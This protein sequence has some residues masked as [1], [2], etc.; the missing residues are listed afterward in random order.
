MVL[1]TN[2]CNLW[3][4]YRATNDADLRQQ[5]ILRY[6]PLVRYVV[7]R[8]ALGLRSILDRDDISSYGTMGLIDAIGHFDPGRGFKFET[9]AISRIRG[10]ILD[11]MRRLGP[12]PRGTRRKM[13]KIA[14]AIAALQ[15]QNGRSP[16]EDEVAGYLGIEIAEYGRALVEASF[17]IVPLGRGLQTSDDNESLPPIEVI[18]DTQSPSPSAEV[19]RAEVRTELLKSIRALPEKERLLIA[20]YYSQEL[21]FKQISRVLE[22]SESRVGQLHAKAILKLRRYLVMTGATAA[23]RRRSPL[24]TGIDSI[25]I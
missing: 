1:A 21:T 19:E 5:L 6:A 10:S 24:L 18:E 4:R 7:G 15:E 8:A 23:G 17:S 13:E 25:V 14:A 22:M 16:T 11:A 9:Y 2:D 3:E 20:L 12:H